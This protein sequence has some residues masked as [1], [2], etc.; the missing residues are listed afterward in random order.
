MLTRSSDNDIDNLKVW[1]YVLTGVFSLVAVV[2]LGCIIALFVLTSKL[3]SKLKKLK[4]E[5]RDDYGLQDYKIRYDL[6]ER[7]VQIL[8]TYLNLP[9]LFYFFSAVRE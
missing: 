9:I 7:C 4:K 2:L 1:V 5:R 3:F 8:Y 6:F